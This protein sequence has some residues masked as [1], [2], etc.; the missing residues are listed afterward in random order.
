[1]A[2][3]NH[4]QLKDAAGELLFVV[5]DS[6][7][8]SFLLLRSTC[9]WEDTY[10][11]VLV[12]TATVMSSQIGYG[13]AAGYLFNRGILSAPPPALTTS[14]GATEVLDPSIN[15]I[16]GM[17]QHE[18]PPGP[19]MTDEEKEREA[20]RLFVLFERLEKA[21]GMENPIKKALHEGRL[22]KYSE[23]ARR[24]EEEDSD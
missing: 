21:G 18:A 13:N 2:C 16:T 23:Q 5:C 6:D 24:K 20:E 22:E 4:Q 10:E 15:P 17:V 8:M 11:I 9:I 19:E 3:V 14:S 12:I 1:M 7:G